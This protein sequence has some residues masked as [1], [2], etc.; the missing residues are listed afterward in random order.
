MLVFHGSVPSSLSAVQ[1]R[2]KSAPRQALPHNDGAHVSATA[3]P[4]GRERLRGVSAAQQRIRRARALFHLGSRLIQRCHMDGTRSPRFG[5]VPNI[6]S[7]RGPRIVD[8][9]ALAL[10]SG[11]CFSIVTLSRSNVAAVVHSQEGFRGGSYDKRN[12]H[13]VSR[14]SRA[15]S[16]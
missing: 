4:C 14:G 15:R 9:R 3:M 7:R 11:A 10:E 8:T 2:R 12:R 16:S 6:R 5:V 13:P 1:A